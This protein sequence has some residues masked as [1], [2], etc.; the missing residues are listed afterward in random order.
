MK[1][2]ALT[3]LAVFSAVAALA[4]DP[5]GGA[6]E[7]IT[8][9]LTDPAR[10]A[11]LKASSVYGSIAVEGYGGHEVIIEA[12]G[13]GDGREHKPPQGAEGM[14]RIPNNAIGLSAVEDNNVVRVEAH[15]WQNHGN[16]HIQVPAHSSLHLS[17][18]NGGTIQVSGVDGEIE[19]GNVNG[20]IEARDV[21][22]S[23]VAHTT[24]GDVKVALRRIAS[25]KPMAFSTFNGNVD[26][27]F[28]ADLRA[29]VR[30]QSGRGDIYSDFEI[31]SGIRSG[32]AVA[33]GKEG[34]HRIAVEQELH[35]TINGG[36]PEI[37]LKTFNG[38]VLIHRSKS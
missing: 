17:C 24:N 18:I 31:A 37:L 19:L 38:N 14:H 12:V 9:P 4:P 32:S 20:S 1:F 8:V 33:G 7:R 36:G 13:H 3:L 25:D 34:M 23:V 10:P 6:T 15:T 26:V 29:T 2:L 16:L 30:V 21:G 22:G 11:T 27:T 5:N 35:G 28:P